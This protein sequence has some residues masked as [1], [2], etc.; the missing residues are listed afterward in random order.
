MTSSAEYFRE[1]R[2][3]DEIVD[4]LVRHEPAN[5]HDERFLR[6]GRIGGE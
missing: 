5:K 1:A 6:D 3:L 2:G 4:A